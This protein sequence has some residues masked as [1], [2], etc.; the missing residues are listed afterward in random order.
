MCKTN[1]GCFCDVDI[2]PK[3]QATLDEIE[4]SK[5]VSAVSDRVKEL[6]RILEIKER[7]LDRVSQELE[8]ALDRLGE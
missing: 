5:I 8:D 7:E 3:V 4:I 6:E 2:N 1:A